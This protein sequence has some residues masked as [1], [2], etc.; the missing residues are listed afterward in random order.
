ML[1]NR[2]WAFIFWYFTSGSLVSYPFEISHLSI[3]D[4][5][6]VLIYLSH[7][8]SCS[9]LFTLFRFQSIR[10]PTEGHILIIHRNGLPSTSSPLLFEHVLYGM[11]AFFRLYEAVAGKQ[12]SG[13]DER[14]VKDFAKTD[15]ESGDK[16]GELIASDRVSFVSSHFA[17][18]VTSGFKDADTTSD[19]NNG[20]LTTPCRT[21]GSRNEPDDSG[22]H[23]RYATPV[24]K[25]RIPASPTPVE[26]QLRARRMIVPPLARVE[27]KPF[28]DSGTDTDTGTESEATTDT[29]SEDGDRELAMRM[30]KRERAAIKG[31][32]WTQ[33]NTLTALNMVKRRDIES[34]F[35]EYMREEG[36]KLAARVE[37]RKAQLKT[38][39]EER[40]KMIKERVER[41]GLNRL[42]GHD[43]ERDKEELKEVK[44]KA[45]RHDSVFQDKSGLAHGEESLAEELKVVGEDVE[46]EEFSDPKSCCKTDAQVIYEDDTGEIDTIPVNYISKDLISDPSDYISDPGSI[47]F[48]LSSHDTAEAEHTTQIPDIRRAF[49]LGWKAASP[50]RIHEGNLAAYNAIS[51]ISLVNSSINLSADFPTSWDFPLPSSRHARVRYRKIFDLSNTNIPLPSRQEINRHFEQSPLALKANQTEIMMQAACLQCILK[52]LPCDRKLPHCG[53]CMRNRE[54]NGACLVQRE[55]MA[56]ERHKIGLWEPKVVGYDKE[57]CMIHEGGYTV[58]V[59]L[60]TYDDGEVWAEK[61]RL[62][63]VMLGYLGEVVER[64][65]WVLPM[66]WWKDDPVKDEDTMGMQARKRMLKVDFRR[67]E[68]VGLV[69][70]I[71]W[72][73][74]EV[75]YY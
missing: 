7:F 14:S 19:A 31:P 56:E 2:V 29:D 75:K 6:G 28:A 64:E 25:A 8:F 11:K 62:E 46:G 70:D 38:Q 69:R 32:V 30:V 43:R 44:R 67:G 68:G 23:S 73:R 37:A 36:E 72:G 66:G 58:L 10:S 59:R 47:S 17:G 65:N 41:R 63:A 16:N 3:G 9:I 55:L 35:E 18:N 15:E 60:R 50:Q 24:P 21:P 53:R 5:V 42:H 34:E 49:E 45:E 40:L 22:Y 20:L 13:G 4:R 57:G 51:T 1:L 61:K 54:L 71:Y 39:T 74:G 12:A 33:G 48:S 26:I 52:Q 27:Q